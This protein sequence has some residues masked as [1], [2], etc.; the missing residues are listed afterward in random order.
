MKYINTM[1]IFLSLI[2]VVSGCNKNPLVV[3]PVPAHELQSSANHENGKN[4]DGQHSIVIDED[5]FDEFYMTFRGKY[6]GS[7]Q[8]HD[9]LDEEAFQA[10]IQ[11]GANVNVRNEDNQTLL[12]IAYVPEV[13][14]ALINAGVEVDAR[15]IHGMTALMYQGHM[16][17]PWGVMTLIKGGADV[18]AKD[19]EG[20]TPLMHIRSIED[21][22]PI[23]EGYID[24][25]C[26][27]YVK[28]L[29]EA[30]AN[31]NEKDNNGNTPL[32]YALSPES[33]QYM[34]KAGA[35]V[36][37][38]NNKG[39]T[40][41][42]HAVFPESVQYLVAA[43]ADVNAKDKEGKT[44]LMYVDNPETIDTLIQAGADVN[45]RDNHGLTA[46]MYAYIGQFPDQGPFYYSFEPEIVVE[47]FKKAGADFNAKDNNNK[48]LLDLVNEDCRVLSCN[49]ECQDAYSHCAYFD[50]ECNNSPECVNKCQE[51]LDSCSK[52]C[53]GSGIFARIN[54]NS[55]YD[56]YEICEK[57]EDGSEPGYE[58]EIFI[59]LLQDAIQS[60]KSSKK[61]QQK[62]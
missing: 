43:G 54:H 32:M 30:G 50:N 24:E 1:I 31:V 14:E 3:D 6:D 22:D 11:S 13:V 39:Q 17:H 28:T 7:H 23:N 51:Q 36:N 15:D 27:E 56:Y 21:P 53:K 58:H 57:G 48:S 18:N 46:F 34:I 40:A 35:D 49:I 33:V 41:L 26:A 62:K 38:R 19:N 25:Y 9:K 12:M 4:S 10:L 61:S 37:A 8:R 60:G 44:A 29:I 20:R 42:M 59:D 47:L 2:F 55:N 5:L 52:D 45:A 16:R